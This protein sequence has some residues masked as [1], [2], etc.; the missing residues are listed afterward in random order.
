MI[1]AS[2]R[3]IAEDL[4]QYGEDALSDLVES[5][6]MVS[7]EKVGLICATAWKY[8]TAEEYALPSGNGMMISKA[9]ALA[10]VEVLEG[11]PRDLAR[12]RRRSA[13]YD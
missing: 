1:L 11:D 2:R 9:V 3:Q 13:A 6:E 5:K 8:A 10:A 7:A 12:K 4:W